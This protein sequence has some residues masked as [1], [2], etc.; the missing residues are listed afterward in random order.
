M[1]TPYPNCLWDARRTDLNYDELRRLTSQWKLAAPNYAGDFYPLTPY[2]LDRGAWI[3]WQFD[4]SE[5]GTGMVQVFRRAASIYRSADLVL[6]GLDRSA[7][8]TITDLDAPDEPR[9]MTG[10]DLLEKGVPVEIGSRPGS[11]LFTYKRTGQG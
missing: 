10:G 11:A 3:G 6:R 4:R 9:E 5:V 1:M 7:R 2:S 8:Y